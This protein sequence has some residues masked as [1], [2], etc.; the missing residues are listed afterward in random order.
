M[1][2]IVNGK[3]ILTDRIVKDK[4]LLYSNVIEGIVSKDNLPEGVEII[5]AKGGYI[6]PGLIDLH[7]HG[8]LGVDTCDGDADGFR[9]MSKGLLANGVTG[10]LPTTMTTDMKVIKKALEVLRDLKEESE[11][12]EG[13]VIFGAH[14]EGPFISMDKRVHKTPNIS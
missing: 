10:Y 5:D 14:A 9:K 1:K 2:A 7:I 3:I 12:W 8:Y 11:T 4:A 6:A 13:S